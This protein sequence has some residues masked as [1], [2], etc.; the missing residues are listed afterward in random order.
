MG[1]LRRYQSKNLTVDPDNPEPSGVCD[2]SGF[3]F[4]HKDLVKQME[5]RGN[6]Y[7]WTGLLVGRQYL[8]APQEQ[9]RPP[10]VK[11]D[12]QPVKN[13][14]PPLPAPEIEPYPEL[15]AKLRKVDFTG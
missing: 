9:L 8:D 11:K 5:W 2:R 3:T 1:F 12:P 15:I 13:P 10:L 14:R 4:N 6:S 7:L